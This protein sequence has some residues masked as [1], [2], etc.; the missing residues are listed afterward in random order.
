MNEEIIKSYNKNGF[1]IAKSLV[2]EELINETV[3]SIKRHFDNQL[4]F[5]NQDIPNNI[6]DSLKLLYRI[7]IERYKKVI[8]S[9]WR[10]M[11]FYELLHHKNIQNFIKINFGWSDIVVSGGQVVHIQADSLR[12]PNG[13][14]GLG[15]HQ[16]FPSVQ[17]SLDGFVVWIPLVNID[18][19]RYP[20]E[21]IP[22]SHKNGILPSFENN[23]SSW[24][25]KPEFYNEMDFI[26]V[27]C[28]IGDV[29][30][31]SNFTVHRSS[32]NGDDRLRLA[33]STRYDNTDEQTFI[34]RCYPSAY[35]RSVYREQIFKI[36]FKEVYEKTK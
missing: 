30:F 1:Y 21:V 4:K 6:Y 19:N 18:K 11:S 2:S 22:R 29:I 24:E 33:C 20:L 16:D 15:V 32:Q 23:N 17:G 8:A 27:V 36:N 10:K 26:P 14:F 13:Y 31:M 12:I 7:D 25:V 3:D 5:L 34:E 35:L 9:L 28:E